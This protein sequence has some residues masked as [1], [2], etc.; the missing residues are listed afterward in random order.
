MSHVAIHRQPVPGNL[1]EDMPFT[2][3]RSNIFLH[4]LKNDSCAT[5]TGPVACTAMGCLPRC[6]KALKGIYVPD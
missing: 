5:K 2:F 1:Q 6:D 3:Q 4:C